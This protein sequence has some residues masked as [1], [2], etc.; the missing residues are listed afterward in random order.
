MKTYM[1]PKFFVKREPECYIQ[2]QACVNQCGGFDTHYY[3]AEDTEVRSREENC[4]GCHHCVP[5][6][7]TQAPTTSR[8]PLDYR[9]NYNWRPDVIEGI[10]RQAKTGGVLLTGK[11]AWGICTTDLC[12]TKRV[13]PDI[14]A[15]RLANLLRGWSIELKDIL[16]PTEISQ[17]SLRCLALRAMP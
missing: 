7:L 17:W 12:L 3:D 6:C 2:C 11:C 9:E 8:N 13:N 5:F 15:R 16:A 4:V 10:I 1:A 14:G